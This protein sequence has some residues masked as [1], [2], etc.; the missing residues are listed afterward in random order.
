ML[1]RAMAAS[2]TLTIETGT[3][4]YADCLRNAFYEPFVKETGIKI[5]T[6]PE[7]HNE[8]KFKLMVE[9]RHYIAD[10]EGIDDSSFAQPPNGLEYLEPID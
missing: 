10:V 1:D 5:L 4:E 3:G 9:T 8:S 2:K 6:A 7:N